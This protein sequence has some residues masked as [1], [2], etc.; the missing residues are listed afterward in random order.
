MG[1]VAFR[2]W[3][4]ARRT[5]PATFALVLLGGITGGIVLGAWSSARRGSSSFDRLVAYGGPPNVIVFFCA[6]DVTADEFG[7]DQDCAPYDPRPEAEAIGRLPGVDAV[8]RTALIF[9]TYNVHGAAVPGP[10]SVALD[11]SDIPTAQGKPVLVAGRLA[12]PD[13]A[14]EVVIGEDA[15]RLYDLGV[16][17]VV[18]F[19][20]FTTGFSCDRWRRDG[21]ISFPRD[22]GHRPDA[23]RSR[24]RRGPRRGRVQ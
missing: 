1:A 11:E 22:R 2:A 7:G 6:P 9:G 3:S 13:V 19:T 10:V 14:E 5:L 24:G 16:G 17:D 4:L 8:S 23:G 20:P 21:G 18:G 12:D 15:A